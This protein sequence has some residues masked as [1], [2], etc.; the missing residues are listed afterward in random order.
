MWCVILVEHDETERVTAVVGPCVDK[1]AAIAR[2]IELAD[3]LG[4]F[5]SEGD[6][7]DL[8]DWGHM[9]LTGARRIHISLMQE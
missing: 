2:A 6:S 1:M 4:E 3:S 9:D 5:V 8:E 7:D